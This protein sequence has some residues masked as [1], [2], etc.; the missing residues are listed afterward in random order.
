MKRTTQLTYNVVKFF[1]GK[2]IFVDVKQCKLEIFS[3][4]TKY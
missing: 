4:S 1:S 2:N 3:R